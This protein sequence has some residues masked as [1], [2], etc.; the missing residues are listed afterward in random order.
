MARQP[1]GYATNLTEMAE[2]FPSSGR[3]VK[4]GSIA[5]V[6]M[7]HGETVEQAVQRREAQR[8][9]IEQ[10]ILARRVKG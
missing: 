7:R 9:R 1:A 6:P 4:G 3:E 8:K 5:A 2:F 10:Q